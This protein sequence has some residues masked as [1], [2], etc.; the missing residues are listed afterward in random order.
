MLA[1]TYKINRH[2]LGRVRVVDGS[3]TEHGSA[4]LAR[5]LSADLQPLQKAVLV[6]VPGY[7]RQK[8]KSKR[9]REREKVGHATGETRR[10]TEGQ[11]N[12]SNA[13]CG[14]YTKTRRFPERVCTN[15][16]QHMP[17]ACLTRSATARPPCQHIVARK[18]VRWTVDLLHNNPTLP[19]GR[20]Q[21]K[22]LLYIP[23]ISQRNAGYFATTNAHY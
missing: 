9:E 20:S 18:L 2:A 13:L 22:L 17:A 14:A 4:Q 12:Q 7:G 21:M 3:E 6:R 1:N 5:V 11:E 23:A 16:P 15:V 10:G 19:A 8:S